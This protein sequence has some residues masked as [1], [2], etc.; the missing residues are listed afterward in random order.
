MSWPCYLVKSIRFSH[1]RIHNDGGRSRH[2]LFTL[3]DGR[4]V[5]FEDLKPGACWHSSL[6]PQYSGSVPGPCIVL[7]GKVIW[8]MAEPPTDGGLPWK[9]TGDLPFITAEPSIN[10]TGRY[11]GWVTNG[12]VSDDCEG[13]LFDEMGNKT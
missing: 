1:W 11:H 7:P 8:R 2:L 4:E 3:A 6:Q 13:R 12:V 10:Y 5:K 9:L